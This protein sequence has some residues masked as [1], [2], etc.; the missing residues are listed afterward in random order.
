MTKDKTI[1]KFCVRIGCSLTVLLWGLSAL[2]ATSSRSSTLQFDVSLPASL[3][4]GSV[5]GRLFVILSQ[6]NRPEPRL[7]LG[8]AGPDA[9]ITL[10]RDLV[11]LAP[12]RSAILDARAFTF[13]ISHLSQLPSGDYF[14]QALF[15]GNADLRSLNA[16]GNLYS[17]AQKFHLAAAS[18]ETIRLELSGQIPPEQLPAETEYI[19]FVKLESKLL[20]RFHRRPIFVRAGIILPRDYDRDTTRRYPLWLRIGGLNTRYSGITRLMDEKSNFRKVWLAGGTPQF[21]LLQLDG[22]GPY[23]DPY[24]VNSANNGPYGDALIQELIPFVEGKFRALGN[25]RARVLSGTSTGGWVSLALQIFNPDFFNGAWSSCPDP[26]DFRALELVNIYEDDNAY[27][28]KHGHEQ[29]SERDLK[30]TTIL[31]MRREVGME[32]LLGRNNSFTMSG[33]QWGAWT[34]AFSPR[35]TDGLPLPLWDAQ[36]GKINHAVAEQWKKYDLRIA[37]AENWTKLAPK[38]RGKLHIAVG[39][40]DNYFL[41]NAVHLLDGSLSKAE[42]PFEGRIVYGP[43]KGHGWMDLSLREMLDEMNEAV[44]P[45]VH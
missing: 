20:S 28:D 23:G 27:M 17:A 10:A 15:D 8:K 1:S 35:G 21:I 3:A 22:A 12:G 32:N 37:L 4:T 25:S 13:P 18:N 7:T 38:L 2:S 16:P 44:G 14:V 39:E 41:N 36:S 30:G 24:Y 42:P 33:Q 40:A 6:T 9:P 43:G 26:V 34:A 19:K 11:G 29:P 5:T 31:T 45:Q